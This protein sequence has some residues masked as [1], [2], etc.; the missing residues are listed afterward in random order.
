M[1]EGN[2]AL[3][4]Y[5]ATHFGCTNRVAKGVG[6]RIV[7]AE[8]LD[9]L[10]LVDTASGDRTASAEPFSELYKRVAVDVIEDVFKG[11]TPAHVPAFD[12]GQRLIHLEIPVLIP[13]VE[14]Y[15][16]RNQRACVI[17]DCH[18]I[19]DAPSNDS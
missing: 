1:Q 12:F 18:K 15:G 10:Q 16:F 11:R 19:Q 14:R 17:S 8:A 7:T 13:I 3:Q 9:L 5:C 4:T 6:R 2:Q